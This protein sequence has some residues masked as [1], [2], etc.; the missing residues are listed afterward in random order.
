MNLVEVIEYLR[1]IENKI[2]LLNG[3]ADA[4]YKKDLLH[5]DWISESE[6]CSLTGISRNTLLKLRQEG[7]IIRSSISGKK[8]YYRVSDFKKLLKINEGK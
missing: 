6:L 5:G 1:R 7:K 4:Q 2:D 8:N 3:K